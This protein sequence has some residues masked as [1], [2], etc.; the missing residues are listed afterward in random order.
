MKKM[1][2]STVEDRKNE[3]INM[4]ELYETLVDS[5]SHDHQHVVG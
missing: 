1:E 3:K 2:L 5:C 4:E